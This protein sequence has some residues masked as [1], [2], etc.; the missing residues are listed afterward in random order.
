MTD[1]PMK[2]TAPLAADIA[3]AVSL[4]RASTRATGGEPAADAPGA[5]IDLAVVCGS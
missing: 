1:Q 2:F 5:T 4:L 3:R